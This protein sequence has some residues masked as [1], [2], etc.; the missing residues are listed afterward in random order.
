LGYIINVAAND[1]LVTVMANQFSGNAKNAKDT[2]NAVVG[3]PLN[4]TLNY[5]GGTAANPASVTTAPLISY[6]NPLGAAPTN[7]SVEVGA[8]SLDASATAGVVVTGAVGSTTLGAVLLGASPVTI[9]LPSTV[10]AKT[11]Y[12]VFGVGTAVTATIQFNGSTAKPVASTDVVYMYN[13]AF[14]RWDPVATSAN[15]FGNYV[16]ITGANIPSGTA[17]ALVTLIPTVPPV[18]GDITLQYPEDGAVNVPVNITFTW[19]SVTGAT[20]YQFAI[21]QDNPDLANKFAVLDYSA[22][23]ITNAHEVQEVLLYDTTYWWEVRAVNG[24]IVSPWSIVSFFTTAKAPVATSTT[25]APP[26]TIVQTTVTY[27][28]PPATT[29]TYTLPQPKETQ[30]IPSYLLWAVIAVGAVLVIAVIVLIVR[31]RRMP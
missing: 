25:T 19:A 21:A 6:A 16:T 3:T 10:V 31:T 15:A 11:Y 28:N 5:W 13:A 1:N 24:T 26:I 4:V 9:A 14:G 30:P 29:I 2:A 22:N 12:D 23:T 17:F 7:G 27:T 8:A 20:G 18:V